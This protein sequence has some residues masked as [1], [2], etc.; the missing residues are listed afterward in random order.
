MRAWKA[1]WVLKMGMGMWP[2][3][4][5]GGYAELLPFRLRGVDM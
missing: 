5:Q 4:A 2:A 3:A 1:L